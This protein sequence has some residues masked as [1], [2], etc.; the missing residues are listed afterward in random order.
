MKNDLPLALGFDDVLI[1]PSYSRV[2]T[3]KLIDLKTDF[4]RNIK[5]NIPLVSANMD[6]VTEARMAIAMAREGGLGI[7]H[8]FMPAD[9]QAYE[10]ERVKRAETL[11]I[12][13][14]ITTSPDATIKDV[15]DIMAKEEVSGILVTSKGGRLEGIVTARD[16]RFISDLSQPIKKI[17]TPK[18]RLITASPN[19]KKEEAIALLQK[20]KLEK[21]PLVNKD[22]VLEGLITSSDFAKNS[23][24]RRSAKDSRGRLLVGAAVGVK[25]GEERAAKLVKAG[26][27]ALVIDIAHGHHQV[28]VRLLKALK[29]QYGE[30]V[31]LVAGNVATK[32]G[33]GDLINAGADAIKVGIGPGRACST[34]VVAGAGVPQFTAVRECVSVARRHQVPVIADGGIKDSGDLSKII[35]AGASTAMIGSLLAGAAESPGDYFMDDGMAF[36]LYRGLASLEASPDRGRAAE[37]ISTRV[38]F[39][40]EMSAVIR[41]LLDGLQ[42]GMSYSGANNLKQFWQKVRFIRITEAGL[43]EGK[44]RP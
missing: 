29:K 15:L 26:A 27:D 32:E 10:I 36:K 43:R 6:T 3:R 30:K 2:K 11:I 21:L 4:S 42:S 1:V 14:P 33:V 38:P 37:G 8:R 41:M 19:I 28:V 23:K 24:Y 17:M 34:R 22:G 20:H 13:E 12:V 7:I 16:V 5:L 25:D 40:G 39:G 31:D 18:L 9:T 35:G 44:P